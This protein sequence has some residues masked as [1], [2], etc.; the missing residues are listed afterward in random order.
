MHAPFYTERRTRGS[1]WCSVIGNPGS[2]RSDD[3]AVFVNSYELQLSI[4]AISLPLSSREAVTFL[5]PLSV[6][7]RRDGL[8]L[9]QDA[10]LGKATKDE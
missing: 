10:V 9:A 5:F 1:V 4:S 6:Q 2:L 8:N 3:K 7:S